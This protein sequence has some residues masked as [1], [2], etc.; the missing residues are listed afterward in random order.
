[1]EDDLTFLSKWKTTSIFLKMEDDL[2]FFENGRRP[3]FFWKWK[4]TYIVLKMEDNLNLLKMEDDWFFL[5]MED[6]PIFVDFAFNK[7]IWNTGYHSNRDDV[8][9]VNHSIEGL[10]FC[11]ESLEVSEL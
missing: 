6:D 9:V 8:W 5:Q 7:L 4:T 10:V 2:N 3:Q 11:N 1:M